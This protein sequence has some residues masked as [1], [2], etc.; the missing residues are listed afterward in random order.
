V[1]A[2]V[3]SH[4]LDKLQGGGN[5]CDLKTSRYHNTCVDAVW[6]HS[7]PLDIGNVEWVDLFFAV[8]LRT[9]A[10]SIFVI[11]FCIQSTSVI[12][13]RHRWYPRSRLSGSFRGTTARL[14][15]HQRAIE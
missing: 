9:C 6:D 5:F 1:A 15:P 4:S 8:Y 12:T 7:E 3:I 10:A 14:K 11:D 2:N 13:L